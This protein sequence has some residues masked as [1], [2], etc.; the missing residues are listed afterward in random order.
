LPDII[1]FDAAPGATKLIFV[2]VVAT[3]GPVN[4]Q[5][6]E[7]LLKV[8]TAAGHLEHQIY[9][10][11]AYSDRASAAFRKTVAELAWGTFAWFASEPDR[12]VAFREAGA[13]ELSS[14]ITA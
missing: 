5:R 3:D 7:A 6:K 4:Q 1:L 9:F 14:L 13:S 2:E 12:I 10:V 11:T 8:A